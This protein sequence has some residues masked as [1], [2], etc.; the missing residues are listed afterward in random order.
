MTENPLFSSFFGSK[1]IQK[2][3]FIRKTEVFIFTQLWELLTKLDE[4]CLL[5]VCV[6]Q[7]ATGSSVI[8]I[9]SKLSKFKLQLYPCLLADI[10]NNYIIN[11]NTS[12]NTHFWS[13][14]ASALNEIVMATGCK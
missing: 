12:F 5:N 4:T 9:E 1:V 6:G 10:I 8:R 7:L 3:N 2:I 13:K 14:G 11:N